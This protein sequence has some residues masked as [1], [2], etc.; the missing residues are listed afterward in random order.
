[1]NKAVVMRFLITAALCLL[2]TGCL[3]EKRA[4]I[5]IQ[6]CEARLS[7]IPIPLNC[8]PLSASISETSFAYNT[9]KTVDEL[10]TYYRAEMERLGWDVTGE[11]NSDES[12]LIFAKPYRVAVISL[13][14]HR[15][16]TLVRVDV[17]H[18]KN[19]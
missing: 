18:H 10:S 3:K 15:H 19:N 7:D 13:R 6:L 16:I 2:C 5:D 1:M 8:R 9:A 17:V 4:P 14:P 11:N 12:V